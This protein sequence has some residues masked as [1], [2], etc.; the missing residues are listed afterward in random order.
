MDE[1]NWKTEINT[2]P[3]VYVQ[4][5]EK[6]YQMITDGTFPVGSRLPSE[7]KLAQS[8]GVSRMTLRQALGLLHDDGL[9]KKIQGSGTFV[10]GKRQPPEGNLEQFRA[11]VYNCC[12]DK[13]DR[14]EMDFRLEVPSPFTTEILKRKTS[15]VVSVDRWYYSGASLLAYTFSSIPV[16]TVSEFGIDLGNR[17]ELQRFVESG[18][19]EIGKYSSLRLYP[20]SE[21]A[22]IV[23]DRIKKEAHITLL[24][25]HVYGEDIYPLVY[26]KHYLLTEEAVFS[27]HVYKDDQGR[28]F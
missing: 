17:E 22:A 16:E 28:T 27:F 8:L 18:I 19:Y 4:V 26:N 24:T 20:D 9:I 21:G 6:L 5:Y 10:T 2:K 23:K 13:I 11:P 14:M 12:K 1:R 7:P 25:E 3:L 15:V